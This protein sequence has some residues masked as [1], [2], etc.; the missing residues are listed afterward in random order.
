MPAE[1]LVDIGSHTRYLPNFV[2]FQLASRLPHLSVVVKLSSDEHQWT[3]LRYVEGGEGDLERGSCAGRDSA[4][5]F[6]LRARA[7]GRW[8]LYRQCLTHIT[9]GHCQ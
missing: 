9:K 4:S 2:P 3:S 6:V 1:D 5:D 8:V 7:R